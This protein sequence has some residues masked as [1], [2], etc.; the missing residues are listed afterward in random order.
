MRSV[1]REEAQLDGAA[2]LV[3]RGAGEAGLGVLVGLDLDADEAGDRGGGA[4]GPERRWLVPA[5]MELPPW[6]TPRRRRSAR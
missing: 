4:G 3:D 1:V 6:K 2:G 5:A